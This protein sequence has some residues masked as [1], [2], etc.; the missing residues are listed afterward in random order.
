MLSKTDEKNIST[1]IIKLQNKI[2]HDREKLKIPGYGSKHK[3]RILLDT[4]TIAPLFSPNEREN[5]FFLAI[6]SKQAPFD[7][8]RNAIRGDFTFIPLLK[9]PLKM[10]SFS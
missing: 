1:L 6:T 7:M 4:Q 5:S 3:V 2:Y 8:Q 10:S 9:A